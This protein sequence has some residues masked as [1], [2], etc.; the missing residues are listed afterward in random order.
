MSYLAELLVAQYLTTGGE[1]FISPQYDVKFNKENKTGGSAPDFVAIDLKRREIVVVEVTTG[2]RCKA[3]V[4]RIQKRQTRWYDV[5]EPEFQRLFSPL[6][7]Q[8]PRVL[9]FVRGDCI[10]DCRAA[11]SAPDVHFMTLEEVASPWL[12][13]DS[14]VGKPLPGYRGDP[15]AT[16]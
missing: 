4:E 9:A 10:D 13:W 1:V 14:R 2:H 3:L 6:N 15:P 12:Y 8:P 7:F 16:P 5:I 11:V